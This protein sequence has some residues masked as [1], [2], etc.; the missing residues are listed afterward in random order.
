M[1]HSHLNMQPVPPDSV[2]P[3]GLAGRRG[4]E[5]LR[6]GALDVYLDVVPYHHGPHEAGELDHHHQDDED[7]GLESEDLR[8]DFGEVFLA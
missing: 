7:A 2:D 4:R 3:V 8:S 5:V 1:V 6:H